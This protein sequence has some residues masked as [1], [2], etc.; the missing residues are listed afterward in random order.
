MYNAL[1]GGTDL[2]AKHYYYDNPLDANIARYEWHTCPCCVGNIPRTLL[3]LP[4]WMYVK[5]DD[6]LYVNLFVGSTVTVEDVAGG[7]V[8]IVQE[9]DYPWD[10]RVTITVNPASRR[11]F[12]VRVR[13]PDRMVSDLYEA[14][15]EANGIRSIAVNGEAIDPPIERGYAVITRT[16]E[17]GDRIELELPLRVQRVHADERIEANRGLVALKYGPLV[18]NIEAEDQD[19]HQDLSPRAPLETEWREDFL[20]GVTVIKGQFANGSPMLAI[21]NFA[22]TNRVEG[23]YGPRRPERRPDGSRGEPFPPV[24]IVWMQEA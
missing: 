11:S 13:V 12:S 24:S 6:G 23:T 14:S 15:P 9:T 10:G 17:P 7:D 1:L 3:M 8:E 22:R 18:Y 21:P 16:W 19:I 5:D 20:G 2:E 4:T